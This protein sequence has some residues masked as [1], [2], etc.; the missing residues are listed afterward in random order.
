MTKVVSFINLK[1]GVGK[2]T[3]AVNIAAILAKQKSSKVLLIDLDPQTNAT[4]SLITQEQWQDVNSKGQ[5]IYHLFN[6]LINSNSQQL[7]DLEKAVLQNV[8]GIQGLDLL[9]SSLE[10]VEIQDDIPS[11]DQRRYVSHVDVI[12]NTIAD[13]QNRYEYVIIDCPP[14]LGA[15]TLNGI[16]MSDYYIVPTIPDIFSKIGLSLIWNRIN[17]FKDKKRSCKVELGGIVFT[18]VDDRTNLHKSTKLQ[19]RQD[20]QW[21]DHTFEHELPQ[22]TGI[23]E[24]V[25]DSRPFVTSPKAEKRSDYSVILTEIENVT[26]EF[27]KRVG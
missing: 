26:E 9:P 10:L 3:T 1:G 27:I 7:F 25:I 11:L 16:V 14:N 12:Q 4:V 17:K 2:T 21:K 23:A 20:S 22:R 5:T 13:I 8:G 18:K 19:I 24:A 6:D 15:I